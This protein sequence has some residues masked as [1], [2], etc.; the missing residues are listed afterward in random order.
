MEN[1]PSPN[2]ISRDGQMERTQEQMFAGHQILPHTLSP[3]QRLKASQ[4]VWS[5]AIPRCF[6][7]GAR[8]LVKPTYGHTKD[9]MSPDNDHNL[10]L[11]KPEGNA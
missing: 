6:C 11:H 7:L 10:R 8:H 5:L 9:S 3:Q 4:S 1:A 2:A